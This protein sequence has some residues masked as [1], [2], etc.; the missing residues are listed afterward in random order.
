MSVEWIWKRCKRLKLSLF[1]PPFFPPLPFEVQV[2]LF[3]FDIWYTGLCFL[4]SSK[5]SFFWILVSFSLTTSVC[6]WVQAFRCWC[7]GFDFNM[8]VI[9]VTG[10]VLWTYWYW[11]CNIGRYIL[12]NK[13]RN[14][15]MDSDFSIVLPSSSSVSW[16]CYEIGKDFQNEKGFPQN[17]YPCR[18]GGTTLSS[19]IEFLHPHLWFCFWKIL[20]E[21]R[22]EV[23]RG[24]SRGCMLLDYVLA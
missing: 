8:I 17:W 5:F 1:F 24:L 22:E 21:E 4:F 18:N 10:C 7:Y 13:W 20:Y 12:Y 11:E 9:L 23:T 14:R 2:L 15:Q 3:W 6:W 16:F 19:K